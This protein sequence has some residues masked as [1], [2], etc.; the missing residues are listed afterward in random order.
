MTEIT[1][2]TG[3][4]PA[5]A[6]TLKAHGLTSAE[7]VAAASLA[8]LQKIGGI[9]AARAAGLKQAADDFSKSQVKS[10][11]KASDDK[12]GA[13]AKAADQAA[14]KPASPRPSVKPLAKPQVKSSAKTVVRRQPSLP[15]ARILSPNCLPK[16]RRR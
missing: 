3:V 16:R 6:A 5:L 13:A 12:G 11:A 10:T 1:K 15:R 4:G 8:D 14:V 2:L 9:G 7:E